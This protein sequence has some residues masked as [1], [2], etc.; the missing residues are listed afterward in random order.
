M[1]IL[2]NTTAPRLTQERLTALIVRDS[3]PDDRTEDAFSYVGQRK[4]TLHWDDFMEWCAAFDICPVHL[5]DLGSCL[6]D[7][8]GCG[9]HGCTCRSEECVKSGDSYGDDPFDEADYAV[10]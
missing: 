5:T 7:D 2:P 1:N 8:L 3:S 4:E 9:A 10:V 6:D